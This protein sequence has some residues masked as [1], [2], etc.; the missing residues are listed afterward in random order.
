M[1][2]FA[3]VLICQLDALYIAW[4]WHIDKLF[5]MKFNMNHSS[6]HSD[7]RRKEESVSR[8]VN[9]IQILRPFSPQDDKKKLCNSVWN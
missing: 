7:D 1:R 6:C 5:K 8:E 2:Q 4:H 3:N 9:C